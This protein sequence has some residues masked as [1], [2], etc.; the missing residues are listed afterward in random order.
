MLLGIESRLYIEAKGF[1][2]EGIL[3]TSFLPVEEFH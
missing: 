1:P 3:S 2:A